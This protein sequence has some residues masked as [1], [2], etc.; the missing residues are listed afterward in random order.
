MKASE[1][2]LE[3][4]FKK[5]KRRGSSFGILYD[6]CKTLPFRP[7]LS[8]IK[9]LSYNS[10]KA[11]VPLIEPITKNNFTVKIVL[12]SL[13][14]YVNKI[15][16]TL[17]PVSMLS[18]VSPICHWRELLK[19]VLTHFRRI[20][21]CCQTPINQCE[22]LLRTALCNNYFLFTSIVYQQ[23][24]GIATDSLLGPNLANTFLAHCNKFGSVIARLSLSLCIIKAVWTI[25]SLYSDLLTTLKNSMNI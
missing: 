21:N 17:W 2:I 3:I 14:K 18:P 9:T 7:I 10:A 20:K 1:T 4:D 12:N 13:R 16:N 11:L 23:V 22:K 19:S 6:K 24:D 15:Q 25:S 5:L 8:T